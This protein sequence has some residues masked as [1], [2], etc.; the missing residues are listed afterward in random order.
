MAPLPVLSGSD[1]EVTVVLG[2]HEGPDAAC[3]HGALIANVPSTTILCQPMTQNDSRY[4]SRYPESDEEGG[5]SSETRETQRRASLDVDVEWDDSKTQLREATEEDMKVLLEEEARQSV[6][7][8]VPQKVPIP[9]LRQ[10]IH[11][12]VG[13]LFRG[14]RTRE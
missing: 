14:D 5:L 6:G 9:N 8:T 2:A 3:L 11:N 1:R 12:Y 10:Q 13:H 7:S 4:A